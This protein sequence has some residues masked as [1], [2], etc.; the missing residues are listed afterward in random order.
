MPKSSINLTNTA[1]ITTASSQQGQYLA[2]PLTVSNSSAITVMDSPYIV[3]DDNS[4][5]VAD[6]E[7]SL[8]SIHSECISMQSD[9]QSLRD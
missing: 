5:C 3:S 7:S 9:H 8:K 6:L 2:Q 4:G 1:A